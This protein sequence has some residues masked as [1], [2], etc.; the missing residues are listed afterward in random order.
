MNTE[1]LHLF[2]DFKAA[3]DTIN[4]E[5]LWAIMVQFGFPYQLIRLLKST[6][7]HVTCCVKVQ[8]SLSGSFESS[9]GLRQGDGLSTKLFNIALEGVIR[10][11]KVETS[12]TIFNKSVQLLGFA[13]D[14][15]IVARNLR[16]LKDSY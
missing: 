14:I 4:R 13:D 2:I 7:D 3:Y 6:L 11:S 9:V 10:I 1:T 16:A 8:G 12:G 15:D 5:D